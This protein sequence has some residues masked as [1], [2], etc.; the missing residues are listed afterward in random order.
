MSQIRDHADNFKTEVQAVVG[1]KIRLR[2]IS[3]FAQ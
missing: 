2:E 3:I 1:W